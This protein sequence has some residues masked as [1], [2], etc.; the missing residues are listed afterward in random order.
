[1]IRRASVIGVLLA[2]AA[3][4]PGLAADS[5]EYPVKAAYLYKFGP[6]VE[7]PPAAFEGPASPVVICVVGDD[8][9]GPMLEKTVEGQ[10]I[11]QRVVTVR[12]IEA[13]GRGSGCHVAY[14]SGGKAQSV[15]EGLAAAS[16][17]AVLTVTD[18]GRPGAVRGVIHFVIKDNRVR[19]HIDDA[20]AAKGGLNISS[21]LLS[22]GLSVRSRKGRG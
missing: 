16:G 13:L 11:G 3:G 7:W 1:M 20:A 2:L 17:M 18:A 5:L 6:F 8:P 15:A 21:K 4:G 9:F 12:R 10:H 19:F 22:L 14:L